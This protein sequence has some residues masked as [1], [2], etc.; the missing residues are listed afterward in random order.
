MPK[1]Q[2]GVEADFGA[3]PV[4]TFN[5]NFRPEAKPVADAMGRVLAP[6]GIVPAKGASGGGPDIG[7]L[8]ESGMATAGLGLDGTD[9]FDFH[10]TADDTL[11][12]VDP[13]KL[14][15]AVAAFASFAWMAADA[16]MALGPVARK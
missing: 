4:I 10:H 12:K 2:A 11:D 5:T 8:A 1:H 3:G 9:Y 13:R 7:P 15:Q 16:P 6:L 14:D